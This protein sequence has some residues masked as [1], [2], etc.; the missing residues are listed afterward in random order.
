MVIAHSTTLILTSNRLT[1]EQVVLMNLGPSLSHEDNGSVNLSAHVSLENE[2]AE[3][4]WAAL[5]KSTHDLRRR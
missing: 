4:S 5:S 1:I 2:R 3:E